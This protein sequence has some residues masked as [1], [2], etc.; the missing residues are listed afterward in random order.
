MRRAIIDAMS[1][2]PYDKVQRCGYLFQNQK[3]AFTIM[4]QILN[5]FAS[6]HVF[7]IPKISVQLL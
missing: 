4:R 2:K 3:N 6:D 1:Q 7:K 5:R